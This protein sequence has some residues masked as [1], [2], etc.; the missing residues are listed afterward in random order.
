MNQAAASK[1]AIFGVADFTW[2]DEAYDA[3]H[4]WRGRSDYLAGRRSRHD[5][6][7][8]AFVDLNHLAPTFGA[9]WQP[10]APELAGS[11]RRVL[12]ALGRRRQAGAVAGLRDY[13]QSIADAPEAIRSGPTDPAFLSDASPWLD[14]TALWGQATVQ[15]LDAVQAGSTATTRP[16]TSSLRRRRPPPRRPPP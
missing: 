6:A 12:G 8:L 15:L 1:I 11:H 13:A 7:L 14:A 4:N 5:A 16:P 2:N 9:P 10:Q 3:G